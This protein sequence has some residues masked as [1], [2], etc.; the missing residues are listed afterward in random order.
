[1]FRLATDSKI[2]LGG[3]SESVVGGRCRDLGGVGQDGFLYGT[4]DHVSRV[5]L[6]PD[7]LLY[8]VW[9]EYGGLILLDRRHLLQ[10]F[11]GELL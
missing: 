2:L 7:D 4:V 11:H 5:Q 9:C 8:L 6:G 10:S 1:M 3:C